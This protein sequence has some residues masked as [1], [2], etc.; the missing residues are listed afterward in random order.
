M[1]YAALWSSLAL[2]SM[3][4]ATGFAYMYYKDKDKRKLIFAISFVF[5]AP[6]H[7]IMDIGWE[8]IPI[9]EGLLWGIF[10]LLSAVLIVVISGILD[11]KDFDKPFKIFLAVLGASTIL[12]F[13]PLPT[14]FIIPPLCQ[15]ISAVSITASSILY[16]KK[17]EISNL[18]FLLSLICFTFSGLAIGLGF[19]AYFTIFSY[20]F[21][22]IF[23][24][25]VFITSQ[26]NMK[27]TVASFFTLKKELKTTQE[28]LTNIELGFS[29]STDAIVILDTKG[30][31]VE[32]NQSTLGILGFSTKEEMTEKNVFSFLAQQGQ[33]ETTNILS[34]N[35]TANTHWKGEITAVTKDGVEFPAEISATAIK[36]DSGKH[37]G[38]VVIANDITRRKQ[39]E[40][41]L[42]NYSEHLEELVQKRTLA[43]EESQ[44]RLVKTERLAAIGQAATM[45][46]HDLRNPLQ[47]IENATH[48]I[49]TELEG[50][51]ISEKTKETIQIIHNSIMYADKI[52]NDLMYFASTRKPAF[53]KENV[54]TI[55]KE[56]ISH[57]CV[58]E[59]VKTV[60]EFDDTCETEVDRDML[61]RVFINLAVNGIQAME[62]NGGTLK[63]STK[64]ANGSVKIK[65]EDTGIGIKKENLKK[66]FTPF[67]TTRAQ[68]MGLG[69]ST[70]KRIVEIHNGFI[71]V[72]S[73]T[74]E[75]STFTVTLPT[76]RQE[77]RNNS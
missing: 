64:R 60:V 66:I 48:F 53:M 35:L 75:G 41:T 55:V 76:R 37:T 2:L 42:R 77:V 56:S 61:K 45:V 9:N 43:L 22:Y 18:M 52:V 68:G 59:N 70:C 63:V 17:R 73:K 28:R 14:K 7:I 50:L 5:T 21:A 46:G 49:S 19:E 44:E 16:I 6:N 8:N 25:L 29:A 34:K 58:P 36:N 74:S 33:N 38:F 13:I 12:M 31:V 72:N 54:N 1:G 65:F 27:G 62:K 51:P 4:L 3:L 57:V 67:F 15:S 23:I 20:A 71:T 40:E 24:G 39:I 32:C 47:A 26:D 10:P 69:L 11:M 30:N